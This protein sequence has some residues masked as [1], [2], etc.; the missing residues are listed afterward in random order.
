[1]ATPGFDA[2]AHWLGLAIGTLVGLVL[3]ILPG[4]IVLV[5]GLFSGLTARSALRERYGSAECVVTTKRAS[6]PNGGR[7]AAGSN[8]SIAGLPG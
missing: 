3:F 6:S 5:V 7:G 8:W 2:N 4:V 1:M